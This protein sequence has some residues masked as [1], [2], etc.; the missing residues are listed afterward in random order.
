MAAEILPIDEKFGRLIEKLR[1]ELGE[2]VCELLD[3]DRRGIILFD[4]R[5]SGGRETGPLSLFGAHSDRILG[6]FAVDIPL[7]NGAFTSLNLA[8][9]ITK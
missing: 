2:T 3:R 1:Y 9:P 8:C 7:K 5:T 4:Y 6:R